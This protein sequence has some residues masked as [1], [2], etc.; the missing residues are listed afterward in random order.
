MPLPEITIHIS[1]SAWKDTWK[2]AR[3]DIK[4]II[5]AIESSLSTSMGE[6]AIVLTDDAAI[7]PLNNIYRGKAKPTN[8]LSFPAEE[9]GMLGDVLLA[10]ETIAREA[11]EQNKTLKAHAMHLVVHGVL[12]LLGYDH[13]NERDAEKMESQEIVILK[14]LGIENP[15][16]SD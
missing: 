13:E 8:V 3:K 10:Y 5:K 15:Y 6:L 1:S 11:E 14:R 2:T 12:H 7:A 16:L 9:E 4:T